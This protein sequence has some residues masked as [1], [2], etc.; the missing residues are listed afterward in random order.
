MEYLVLMT[1]RV[2]DRIPRRAIPNDSALASSS[3]GT[4]GAA[5]PSS[6]P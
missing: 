2:P 1:T 4:A 3:S 6:L 5:R